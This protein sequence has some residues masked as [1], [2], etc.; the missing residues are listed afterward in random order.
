MNLFED[1]E[2]KTL[3]KKDSDLMAGDNVDDLMDETSSNGI[4][5]ADKDDGGGSSGGLSLRVRGFSFKDVN[6]QVWTDQTVG[7]VKRI[8]RRALGP[9]SEGR[10]LRLISKGRMLSPDSAHVRDFSIRNGDVLHAALAPA[11]MR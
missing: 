5:G 3:E 2:D 6:I 4:N 11:G 8:V 9:T 10:Y 7:E 1:S